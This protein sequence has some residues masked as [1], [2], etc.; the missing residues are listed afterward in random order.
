MQRVSLE[1]WHSEDDAEHTG[2]AEVEDLFVNHESIVDI[3]DDPEAFLKNQQDLKG[4]SVN[5]VIRGIV[6]GLFAACGNEAVGIREE[7]EELYVQ[8][9]H[10][11]LARLDDREDTGLI[12]PDV[13]EGYGL[14]NSKQ[15][16]QV[17]DSVYQAADFLGDFPLLCDIA[18]VGS[19]IPVT[20]DI[21][22]IRLRSMI[23]VVSKN[24]RGVVGVI[25][26]VDGSDMLYASLFSHCENREGDLKIPEI[27]VWNLSEGRISAPQSG[28]VDV[29]CGA[30]A[31]L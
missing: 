19:S 28:S 4:H 3:V 16:K 26:I 14:L 15:Q 1:Y 24:K 23:P 10:R 6:S 21:G 22:S 2:P 8:Y 27:T 31:S 17:K 12:Y 25:P 13:C 9:A 18:V 5:S 30:I 29:L 7:G 20:I 11:L